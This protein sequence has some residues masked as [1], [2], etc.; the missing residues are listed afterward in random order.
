MKP[1]NKRCG[2]VYTLRFEKRSSSPWY[3]NLI[4]PVVCIFLAL[5]CCSLIV[6]LQGFNPW[7]VYAKMFSNSFG[8]SFSL[9]ESM[10]QAIPLIFCGL[11]VSVAFRMSLNNIGAEGQYA[12]GTFAATGVALFCPGI[13]NSII[14][15][16][17]ILAGFLAGALL[18]VIAIIPKITLGLN[19]TIVTLML[20]YIAL[21]FV[22]YWC[23]GPWR[24]R[25]G[26]N[27]P[28]S[29][30]IPDAAKFPTFGS[31]RLHVGLLLA[32]T[33]AVLVCLFFRHTC[34]G[35]QMRVIGRNST[36]ARYA[37]MNVKWNIILAMLISGGLAGLAG[38]TQVGGAIFRLEPDMPNGAGF[39]AVVI[40]YL[41]HF[42]PFVI[43]LVSFLFGGLTQ[44]GFSLQIMGVSSKIV[45]LIQGTILFFVLGGEIFCRN[46]LVLL[47]R[48]R[49]ETR[50]EEA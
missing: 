20:N 39:T 25:A 23:Y 29:P 41:A 46:R 32:L 49:E 1:R 40:A 33:M 44:G 31:S 24:D 4:V 47:R 28:Y 48:N 6:A 43:V 37:G 14:L 42:D 3:L 2:T 7:K 11:G 50:C 35:Y 45:T 21:L 19:E 16:A 17:M 5:L 22:D 9:L 38:V 34:A 26:N 36:A 15:P 8:S 30:I 12:L 18:A 27:M 13:P 10:L